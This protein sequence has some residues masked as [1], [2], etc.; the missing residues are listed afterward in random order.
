MS[1]GVLLVEDNVDTATSLA[2]LVSA[3]G[4]RP[5]VAHDGQ[6]ALRAVEADGL[7]DVALLDIGLPGM[8]GWE[9]ARRLRQLPTQRKLLLVAVTGYTTDE[10]RA[11][12]REAG[13]D[14]HLTKP[15]DP[16]ALR[17]VLSEFEAQHGT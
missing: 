6:A 3:F 7:P 13:I 10:D 1:L 12:S 2:M 11:M 8:N 17:S 14:L 16:W 15:A 5:R 9:V 4:H